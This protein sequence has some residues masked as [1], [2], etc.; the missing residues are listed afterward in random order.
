MNLT[1]TR[2]ILSM[3]VAVAGIGGA[4]Y[5]T[6]VIQK[7]SAG[8]QDKGDWI[9][10]GN[11]IKVKSTAY[12]S[13]PNP[14]GLNLSTLEAS[15][16]LKMNDV[17]LAEGKKKGLNVPKNKNRSLNFTTSLKTENIP[18][19]WAS[20]LRNGEE[21]RLRIPITAGMNVG[22]LPLSGSYT[23][24]DS[25]STDIESKLSGSVSEL[26][27]NY[28]RQLGPD[29]GLESNNMKIA[30]KDAEASFGAVTRDYTELVLPL[31]VK[32][33]NDYMIPTP[34]LK[35]N[36][37]MNDIK[38][39]DFTANNVETLSDTGIPAGESRKVKVTARM[40]NQNIDQWFE[41]HVRKEE[42]TDAEL[43]IYFGFDVGGTTFQIPSDDGMTCRFSFATKI[44][45]DEKAE[46]E[47]FKRCTGI[48]RNQNTESDSQKSSDGRLLGNET[49][50]E[51]GSTENSNDSGGDFG[52]FL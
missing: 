39:A 13:N 42:K 12:V 43:N 17:K 48:I 32:N 20:H 14:L 25:I 4:A 24:R 38:I 23:Y 21:S 29:I 49:G 7:P 28:S 11:G 15:Y 31:E 6:G 5:A 10:E 33:R 9:T 41:S 2:V 45:V 47:G 51:T 36:L 26:E 50:G 52:G 34:Q 19:W 30:V 46:A 35:G 16:K 27:G 8:L 1:K 3:I 40:S 18:A 22:P 44:L 37:K